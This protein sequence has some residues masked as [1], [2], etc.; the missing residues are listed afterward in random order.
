MSSINE[1]QLHLLTLNQN[2]RI[3]FVFAINLIY[4]K[5]SS[6]CLIVAK[7]QMNAKKKIEINNKMFD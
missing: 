7:H 5:M 6:S 2:S 4:L 3:K 1:F